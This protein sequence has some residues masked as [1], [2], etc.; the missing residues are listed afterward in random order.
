RDTA[1]R[2]LHSS[3][4][5]A[6][7]GFVSAAAAA[8]RPTRGARLRHTV[9]MGAFWLLG[10]AVVALAQPN[11]DR[12]LAAAGAAVAGI[13]TIIVVSRLTRDPG[14]R[15]FRSLVG[16][17]VAVSVTGDWLV[18]RLSGNKNTFLLYG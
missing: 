5:R 12:R 11:S 15:H 14:R 13:A 2:G 10:S 4:V 9:G 6:Q 16:A 8:D 1:K 3:V 18:Q 7:E 17:M